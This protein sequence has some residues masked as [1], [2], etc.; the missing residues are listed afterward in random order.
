MAHA[1]I[2][3]EVG[4][5]RLSRFESPR[6]ITDDLVE[7][8]YYPY[9]AAVF[10]AERDKVEAR[11][12]DDMSRDTPLRRDQLLY[13]LT[14]KDDYK[15]TGY[16]LF[17]DFD[18]EIRGLHTLLVNFGELATFFVRYRHEFTDSRDVREFERA[19]ASMD[20]Q[21]WGGLTREEVT[22]WLYAL[23]AAVPPHEALVW[24]VFT[25][26]AGADTEA[27]AL[28]MAA[29]VHDAGYRLD[30]V[31]PFAAAGVPNVELMV[32]ALDHDI[33]A[34]LISSMHG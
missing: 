19:Y 17:F 34:T 30:D 21:T 5:Y 20:V 13:L 9:A 23:R 12:S 31:I 15:K 18:A 32:R 14:D 7:A 3:D 24:L 28:G 4:N 11:F 29:M 22:D 6:P 27:E 2:F 26:A 10:E 8:F 33:D 1:G 16:R 25:V